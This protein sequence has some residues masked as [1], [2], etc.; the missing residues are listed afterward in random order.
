M[1]NFEE[2]IDKLQ[3][4]LDELRQ[5]TQKDYVPFY[6]WWDTVKD[7]HTDGFP[8]ETIA[9]FGWY[10]ALQWTEE[11]LVEFT[12]KGLHEVILIGQESTVRELGTSE[13][14]KSDV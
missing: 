8:S 1:H 13:E 2:R 14:S 7:D 3:K 6:K 10:S 5:T 11:N 4:E 9:S 12:V